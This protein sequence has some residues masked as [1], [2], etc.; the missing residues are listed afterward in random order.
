MA[1]SL[2]ESCHALV[3]YDEDVVSQFVRAK[4]LQ[5]EDQQSIIAF[6]VTGH[7]KSSFL[8]FILRPQKP[9]FETSTGGLSGIASKTKETQCVPITVNGRRLALIDTP[10]FCDT[11]RIAD[12]RHQEASLLVEKEGHKFRV[13]ITK[14][15]IE[16]GKKVSAFI[17]IYRL[18]SRL[19]L[20][21]TAQLKFLEDIK[22]PWD[23]CILVMTHGDQI[24]R[25]KPKEKWYKAFDAEL[26]ALGEE[27]KQLKELIQRTTPR[28]MLVDSTCRDEKYHSAVMKRFL[29][30]MKQ[31]ADQRGPYE[32][33]H[34]AFFHGKYD[35]ECHSAYMDAIQDNASLDRLTAETGEDFEQLALVGRS[36]I[37]KQEEFLTSFHSV[38][39]MVGKK[40][41][42]PIIAASTGFGIAAIAAGVV[43]TVVGTALIPVTFGSST[44]AVGVGIASIAGGAVVAAGGI[45][46][47]AGIPLIKKL[48]DK[49]EVKKA[50]SCLDET[51]DAAKRFYTRYK[52]IMEKISE[53]R[54]GREHPNAK[55]SLFSHL[56]AIHIHESTVKSE[57]L[58]E[59]AQELGVFFSLRYQE[60]NPSSQSKL[61]YTL[62]VGFSLLASTMDVAQ[63]VGTALSVTHVSKA[64]K[65]IDATL[66]KEC[67]HALEKEF[68]AI[69]T[70]CMYI[71][72]S[73]SETL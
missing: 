45:G 67:E 13:N 40:T 51:I 42:T 46:A 16:A 62:P 47:A 19:S 66:L 17:F 73:S 12:N 33:I 6:G 9:I 56:A 44:F 32:N 20:E 4:V 14:A 65:E 52:S 58:F 25:G 49:V 35:K 18:D 55:H 61:H 26:E 69:K 60:N 68:A 39:D 36:L 53:D 8:N 24:Y 57:A 15:F 71:S 30:L 41:F 7:G 2:P 31:I 48:K 28:Y 29:A 3:P 54:I 37:A 70:L 1:Q 10:G 59:T 27:N 63:T 21:M 72:L 64:S 34:F 50:Q 43:A 23:H 38:I 22:F 5:Q 11:H